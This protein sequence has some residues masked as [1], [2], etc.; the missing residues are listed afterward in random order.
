MRRVILLAALSGIG[1]AHYPS[2]AQAFS[3]VAQSQYPGA[4]DPDMRPLLDRLDRLERDMNMV[5]R[6]VYRSAGAGNSPAAGPPPDGQSALAT[7]VRIGQLEDQMRTLT[8][9]IE[10]TNYNL[11]Q[12]KQRLDKLS[13]DIDQ[14]LTALEHGGGGGPAADDGGSP[15]P[16]PPPDAGGA[17]LRPP[18]R[19]P[20]SS[21]NPALPP[22]RSGILGTIPANPPPVTAPP[23]QQTAAASAAGT[24]PNGTAQ[25]QYDYAFGLLRQANYAAAESALRSFVQHYPNDPLS[26]NAQYWLGETYYVRQD[27]AAA[28]KAFAEGYEK[29]PKSGKA[30]DILLKLGLSFG[31]LN[32]KSN[33]CLALARLDRD[34]PTAPPNIKERAT[35]EKQRLGC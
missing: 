25:Q 7:E 20:G 13:G 33:A 12:I 24:L 2:V 34:F 29:Y 6:Q 18:Q 26:G 15:P 28:V 9:Q 4:Q 22:S 16:A 5:Q 14:R 17:G 30:A 23:D 11:G 32:Q 1:A 35:S 8:G 10:E 19:P 31:S 27:Y 3:Q 21:A